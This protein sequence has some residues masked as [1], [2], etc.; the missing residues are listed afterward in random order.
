MRGA[1]M[2]GLS[3]RHGV[4]RT[5]SKAHFQASRHPPMAFQQLDF[6]DLEDQFSEEELMVRDTVRASHRASGKS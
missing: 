1:R 4:C 2:P 5:P 6:F 3:G